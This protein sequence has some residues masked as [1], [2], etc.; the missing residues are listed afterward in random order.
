MVFW[1]CRRR[2]GDELHSCRAPL[3]RMPREPK[4]AARPTD[5]RPEQASCG[6][7]AP[8]V[9]IS[10]DRETSEN[11]TTRSTMTRRVAKP[12]ER[13]PESPVP[14]AYVLSYKARGGGVY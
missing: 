13:V 12:G 5:Y 11:Y 7:F 1:Q 14:R 2:L 4:D 10:R 6:G 3:C 8:C 9:E